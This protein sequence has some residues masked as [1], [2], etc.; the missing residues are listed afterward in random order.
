MTLRCT[1]ASRPQYVLA[2]HCACRSVGAS[3]LI[4]LPLRGPLSRAKDVRAEVLPQ[5][6]QTN[7]RTSAKSRSMA[8]PGG[9][10]F[11]LGSHAHGA[12][13]ASSLLTRVSFLFS[14]WYTCRSENHITQGRQHAP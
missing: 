8:R 14:G 3:K 9:R 6:K 10:L 2:E 1:L 4:S 7:P 12:R 13:P 11:T 5:T